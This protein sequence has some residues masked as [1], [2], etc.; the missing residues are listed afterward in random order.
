M[1]SLPRT[2]GSPPGT[3]TSPCT[4]GG[5]HS[6][7]VFN[8]LFRGGSEAPRNHPSST[9]EVLRAQEAARCRR[10]Q[11]PLTLGPGQKQQGLGFHRTEADYGAV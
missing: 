11:K 6:G 2:P 4:C 5:M 10:P 9:E 3:L 8:P 1:G 7:S